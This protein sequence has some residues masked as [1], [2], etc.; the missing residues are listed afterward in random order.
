MTA[1]EFKKLE[2]KLWDTADNLRANSDLKALSL[3]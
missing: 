1:E 3:A 2:T